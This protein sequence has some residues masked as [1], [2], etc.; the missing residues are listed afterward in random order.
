MCATSTTSRLEGDARRAHDLRRRCVLRLAKLAPHSLAIK[1]LAAA[2]NHMVVPK[3]IQNNSSRK[4]V[5][6]TGTMVRYLKDRIFRPEAKHS[7]CDVSCAAGASSWDMLP[8]AA[9][10]ANASTS[11]CARFV[12]SSFCKDR[13]PVN[14]VCW[15]PEGRRLLAGGQNGMFTLWSGVNFTFETTQQ[16]HEAAVRA[17]VWSGNGDWMV[18][19]DHDGCIKYWAPTLNNVKEIPEAHP[20]SPVRE[21]CF[22]PS[23]ALFCSCS[24]DGTVKIWDFERGALVHQLVGTGTDGGKSHGWDVKTAQWH[25]NKSLIVSGSKDN[26][27]KLWEP[28]SNREIAT[29]HS[30]KNTINCVRWHKGGDFFLSASR[31]QLVKLFDMRKMQE[32]A[33]FKGHK[34]EVSTL[35][36]HPAHSEL[37]ASGAHDGTLYYWSTRHVDGP[38]GQSL[39]A[40]GESAHNKEVWS[41]SWHP[42]GH[43]I[44]SGANDNLVKFWSRNRPGDGRKRGREDGDD[45]FDDE[46]EM[47]MLSLAQLAQQNQQVSGGT[48][49]NSIT[50]DSTY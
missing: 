22:S 2:M 46:V 30:H 31:D 5:D 4:I 16:A 50:W 24:D 13:C 14:A 45:D 21:I 15:T 39:G 40:R 41:L 37:F 9:Q 25:P 23:S 42:L 11:V 36:W 19:A 35:A 8:P 49:G 27:I 20:G 1:K 44:C 38:I 48:T 26:C 6:P 32:Y 47:R 7:A 29:L 3:L 34:R 33:A 18:S 43:L 28:K 12:H 10:L 17:L